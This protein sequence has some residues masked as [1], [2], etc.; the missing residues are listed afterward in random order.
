MIG[1]LTMDQ[2]Q[3]LALAL[4]VA[5]W[6]CERLEATAEE[7]ARVLAGVRAGMMDTFRKDSA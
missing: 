1:T 3:L 6:E 7:T 4:I 5:R 2:E